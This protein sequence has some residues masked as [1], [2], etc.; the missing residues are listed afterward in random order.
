MLFV[1][2]LSWLITTSF[3]ECILDVTY[4]TKLVLIKCNILLQ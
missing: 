1:S 4:E 3:G 2:V